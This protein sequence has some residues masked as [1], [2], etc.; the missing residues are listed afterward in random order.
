MYQNCAILVIGN[1]ILSGRTHELNAW[2]CAQ[3]LFKCGCRLSE[4]AVIADDRLQIIETLNRFR[5]QYDAVICS[6]GIGPTHD[7][8]TMQAVADAFA[9]SLDEH[10]SSLAY[11]QSYYNERSEVL[12]DGRRR[13]C[14]LPRGAKPLLCDKTI[15]PGACIEN[16]YVL[17][18]VPQIFDSQFESISHLFG[19]QPFMRREIEVTFAES[20]FA[21]ALE[22]LATQFSEVEMG[23][24]PILCGQGANG[25]ICLS[26]QNETQLD[27]AEV[28]VK[29]M[30][31]R[32]K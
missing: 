12:N 16:V 29:E 31:Q 23:S 11:M 30:L 5:M 32:L 18:G 15:A 28:G 20:Q 26:S 17:A 27:Q 1:E 9:V 4:I 10:E 3:Q 19:G 13:M 22:K 21:E 24:Y 14:R 25:R 7:D 2:Q 6:G 8:I